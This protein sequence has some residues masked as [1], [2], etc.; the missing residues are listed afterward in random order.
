VRSPSFETLAALAPQD[1]AF[2][3]LA[4]LAPQ[5]EAFETLAA[6]APQD[7]AFETLALMVR[8]PTSPSRRAP[9]GALLR[10]RSG[11]RIALAPQDE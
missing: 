3:T 11:P 7:E 9:R 4:A 5:D 6:L 8:C 1:E 10:M 2:E